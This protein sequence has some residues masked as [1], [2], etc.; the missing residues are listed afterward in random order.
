M[1]GFDADEF[2][3]ACLACLQE[4]DPLA[5]VTEVVARAVSDPAALAAAFPVPIDPDDDGI[6]HRSADLYVTQVVFPKGFR[7]GVHDHTIPAVIGV[8]G[9]YEDNRVYPTRDG[10]LLEGRVHRVEP[11]QV[12]TLGADDAHDVHAPDGSWS[13]AVHV[14][15]GDLIALDRG[16]WTSLD[17]ERGRYDGD[18]QERRWTEA[19]KATGLFQTR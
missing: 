18:E 13:A 5:A 9:G 14:Y 1:T 7:T 2:V 8:W 16:L 11:G 15:L 12:L 17:G 19:A 6:I 3:H 10:K 4:S